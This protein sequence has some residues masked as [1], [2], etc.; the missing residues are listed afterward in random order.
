MSK[1]GIGLDIGIA[2]V[3]WAV[4]MLDDQEQPCGII[5]MGSRVF[6][7]AEHPKTGASLAAPRRE[8]RS[9][10]RRTRR[11]RHRNERIRWLLTGQNVISQ[12]ELDS[13]FDGQLED[14]YALRVR[15]LDKPVTNTEFARI[16]IHMAQR[17]G[18][19]SNRKEG[20]SGEDGKL[21]LAVGE[22][23]E[24]MA[25]KGYRTVGEM[26]L[27]D[28]RF[29]E[30]K[31]NKGGEYIST[32]DRS[33]VEDEVRKIYAAQRGFGASFASQELEE[34]YLAILLGQ[35]SFD[36]G[37]GGN[38][39]Y[40]G[41]QIENMVG[42]CTLYPDEP[43]AAKATYSFEYFN[44]LERVNHLRLV[45]GGE[46]VP[47]TPEQRTKLLA[48]AH[49]SE[50]ITYAKIRKELG[51]LPEEI[52]FNLVHYPSGVPVEETEKKEKFA[53][54]KAYH[55]MRKA[56]D[57]VAKGR[58][59][60][61]PIEHRNA[62]GTAL[63]L[64]KT[65]EKIT[66]YLRN[67]GLEECDIQAT[68]DM[69]NFSKFGHL[70]VK[71]C[72]QLI[73]FLEQGM[74][75]NDACTAAGF[76]FKAH[77]GTERSKLLHITD[78][79][80]ADLTSPVVKRAISQTVKVINAIIRDQGDSPVYINI[81]LARE[82]SK[83]F[84]E[85][86]KLKKENEENRAKN[87][88]VLERI[89][90]EYGFHKA[91]GQD[92]VKMKLYEE[93]SGV[94][95]YSQKNLDIERLFEP[96]YAEVD[97]IIPYSISFD[98]SYKNK[99]LVLAKENR[100]KGNRLPLQY[101]TGDRR[102]KF[103]VWVNACVKNSKKRKNLLTERITEDDE[104]KF[105]ER[106]LQDTKTASRFLMNFIND[107]LEFA[108]SSVG[109]KKKVTAV[110]GAVTS[111][112]RKRWGITK[113]REDGDLHH[114]VDALTIACTTDGM[115]QQVSRYSTFREC[116]YSQ[117]ESGSVAYDP[118][119]GEVLRQF[120]Y[121]WP[122]FRK[123]LEARLEDDP[124]RVIMDLKLPM[125]EL[126]LIPIPEKP[127]FVSRMP[128][129]KV[130]GAAH[131]DTVKSPKALDQGIV[132][133]KKSLTDLK[134]NKN[135]EI[136]NYYDPDGDP[137]LYEA[138]KARLEAFGGDGKKAFAE[139]FRKPSKDGNGPLVKKVKVYEPTTLNVPLHGGNGVADNDSMVRIDVFHVEGDGYYWVPIYIADTLKPELPNRAVVANKPYGQ[140]KEM[141]DEDFIFSLYPNDLVEIRHKK[142]LKLAV[143]NKGGSL[144]ES[145]EV[146]SALLYYKGANIAGGQ[147]SCVTH[148]GA[149]SVSSLGIK[150][151]ASMTK[152]T[153]DVLGEYHPVGKEKRQPFN[154]KRS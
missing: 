54:L 53:F 39:P 49:K 78:E 103:L 62:I 5:K 130:T 59:V 42:K 104:K 110:N 88:A 58:I 72:N 93:Q 29:A 11:H 74:N 65:S 7:A 9:A 86:N 66:D 129:R 121:P 149:Y 34:A 18:F 51:N 22:N 75:Y 83:D 20:T 146:S 16:L 26:L 77:S 111:Y 97:H 92:I 119:T 17:R 136:D 1:Y 67:A 31:R 47:L 35:R 96:G 135:G 3:G 38:S 21:L 23:R 122:K 114:A 142:T 90:S 100:D 45:S 81:E 143:S 43:R 85:R 98:D 117:T 56:L 120:P 14:I 102:D 30:N 15:A 154:M 137:T 147:I 138:L 87:Q 148:D 123:E 4:V 73:P 48:L 141:K 41:S 115:I 33:M 6:S 140:W 50:N 71:A 24:R 153:V 134:L 10:R 2:S 69:G 133:V 63:S 116:E 79:D 8:A 106:N 152:Y 126:G 91:S 131:K 144:P 61:M 101:L 118:A 124:G 36:E 82:M 109:R 57:K 19:R 68:E 139:P 52:T 150:T 44:L 60:S 113:I 80:L 107:Y 94:C 37:P 151:L 70:S 105:K 127:I 28:P 12:E 46:S 125:Y 128:T 84:A 27:N 99:V 25:E 132:I 145:I 32:V 76:D 40:G 112:M 108:P 13:L 95:A 89:Q 55:Q 64:Y